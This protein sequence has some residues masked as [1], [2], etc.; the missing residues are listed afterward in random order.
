MNFLQV[1]HGIGYFDS[2][3]FKEIYYKNY[4][5]FDNIIREVQQENQMEQLKQSVSHREALNAVIKG[6]KTDYITVGDLGF[7]KQ[8]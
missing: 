5:H 6:Y 8:T 7:G 3:V 1:L 4:P 2:S